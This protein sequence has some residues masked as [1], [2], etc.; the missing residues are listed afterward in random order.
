MGCWSRLCQCADALGGGRSGLVGA[1]GGSNMN[2]NQASY[3]V[4]AGGDVNDA[5]VLSGVNS[6]VLGSKH[7]S[8]GGAFVDSF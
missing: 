2:G 3:N 1:N 6:D 7:T 8:A 5:R 4:V